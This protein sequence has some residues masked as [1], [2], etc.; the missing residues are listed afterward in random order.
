MIT[1]F[2]MTGEMFAVY[3]R[4]LASSFYT[5]T[6]TGASILIITIYGDMLAISSLFATTIYGTGVLVITVYRSM[7][8]NSIFIT[9]VDGT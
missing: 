7:S 3:I 2:I 4:V 1:F 5:T 9:F 8:N 6:V